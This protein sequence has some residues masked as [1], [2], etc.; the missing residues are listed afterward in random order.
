MKCAISDCDLKSVAR[1]Y[2]NPHYKRLRR[3]GELLPLRKTL[4]QRLMEKCDAPASD[5]CWIW[6]A[7]RN[8]YGYGIIAVARV[9]RLA[10]RV[11]YELRHGAIPD[12]LV[13]D[14]LC[15]N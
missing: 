8:R 5:E 1:G 13:L 15:R 3:S 7:G 11:S 6:L 14:H 4:L 9:S 12:G 10:H 2:C